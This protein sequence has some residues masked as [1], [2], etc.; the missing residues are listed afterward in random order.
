MQWPSWDPSTKIIFKIAIAGIA[1]VFLWAIRDIIIVLLLSV[2]LASAMEPMVAYLHQRRIPRAVSVLAVYLLVLG[3][4]ALVLWLLV[5]IAVNQF[6]VLSQNLPQYSGQLQDRFLAIHSLLGNSNLSDVI[7]SL[8]GEATKGSLVFTGT[9]GIFNGF[10]T[11]NT[12]RVS[13]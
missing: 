6:Q 4:A 8:F 2:I 10:F 12:L 9:V 11:G 3:I 13:S 5:P 1:L 7:K